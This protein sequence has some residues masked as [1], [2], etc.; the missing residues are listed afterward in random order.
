M[1]AAEWYDLAYL[2]DDGEEARIDALQGH[3]TEHIHDKVHASRNRHWHRR[4]HQPYQL[5]S[6]SPLRRAA[7]RR[8]RYDESDRA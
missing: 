8:I 3:E 5:V 7:V 4:L 1:Q 6:D 2:R